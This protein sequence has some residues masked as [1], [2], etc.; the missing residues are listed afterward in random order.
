MNGTQYNET[1]A[2][3]CRQMVEGVY[4]GI[5]AFFRGDPKYSTADG[6]IIRPEQERWLITHLNDTDIPPQ[7]VSAIIEC[8]VQTSAVNSVNALIEFVK[9]E[10]HKKEL[11]YQAARA[12]SHIDS[13][14]HQKVLLELHE[15]SQGEMQSLFE[16]SLNPVDDESSNSNSSEGS[17]L[18]E[19]AW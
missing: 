18:F 16:I 13:E 3:V 8:F 11:R 2:A 17:S 14:E 4:L 19:R 9:N 10:G 7:E 12:I 1:K 15:Q 6:Y 5:A